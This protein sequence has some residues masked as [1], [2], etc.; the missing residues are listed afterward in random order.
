VIMAEANHTETSLT[1]TID[2]NND[3][4]D[5]VM[6][7]ADDAASWIMVDSSFEKASVIFCQVAA[8][9]S[10]ASALC[11]FL[12]TGYGQCSTGN[13]SNNNSRKKDTTIVTRILLSWSVGTM[14]FCLGY[15][16]GTWPIPSYYSDVVW[17]AAG[18]DQ[19]CTFQGVLISVGML[20]ASLWDIALSMTYVFVVP[21]NWSQKSLNR[22][23]M[24][25]HGFIW[26]LV[27]GVTIAALV[28]QSF[29]TDW[30]AC[31]LTAAPYACDW[32]GNNSDC[33]RGL[34][35]FG[36]ALFLYV[37]NFLAVIAGVS[38]MI[39]LYCFV[40]NQEWR[41]ERYS[42]SYKESRSS[43]S[44]SLP[45][46]N[47]ASDVRSSSSV[48]CVVDS[49]SNESQT[50]AVEK[51]RRQRRLSRQVAIQGILYGCVWLIAAVPANAVILVQ[52]IT[53]LSSEPAYFVTQVLGVLYGFWYL[54]VFLRSKEAMKTCYGR[55]VKWLLCDFCKGG[56]GGNV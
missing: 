40:R 21:C 49:E 2:A 54:L 48:M 12:E 13:S 27:L 41:N 14:A 39:I 8:L 28:L 47:V 19:T 15:M 9:V 55:L 52:K 43:T 30:E 16:M 10:F 50:S 23:E 36:F 11:I 22:W 46:T 42:S 26:P 20:V 34:Q 37:I 7:D 6:D 44:G 31:F 33:T 45:E 38:S 17:A 32:D 51:Q 53:G 18:N 3:N 4:D 25:L 1:T 24:C 5:V 56:S 29:N 35:A